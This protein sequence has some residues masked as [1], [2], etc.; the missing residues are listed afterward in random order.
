MVLRLRA[1]KPQIVTVDNAKLGVVIVE[2]SRLAMIEDILKQEKFRSS[3]FA[4]NKAHRQMCNIQ[5]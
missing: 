5:P 2:G 1:I 4:N 3:F